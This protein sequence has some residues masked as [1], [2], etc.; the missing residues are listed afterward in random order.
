MYVY[1]QKLYIAAQSVFDLCSLNLVWALAARL[2][3][4]LNPSMQLHLTL[5][6]SAGWVPPMGLVLLLWVIV[7]V[8]LKLYRIPH[9]VGVFTLLEGAAKNTVVLCVLTV[10]ATFFSMQFGGGASRF[11]VLCMLPVALLVLTAT[12]VLTLGMVALVQHRAQ[13][14]RIALIGD[15]KDAKRLV[16]RMRSHV[17]SD[18][19][20]VI[21]PEGS[22]AEKSVAA[23]PVL[24]TTGQIAELVNRERIERVIMLKGTLP[25]SEFDRCHKVFWRMGLPVTC[26]LDLAFEPGP[27][28]FGWGSGRRVD[29]WKQYGLSIVEVRPVRLTG[30]QDFVKNAFD[31]L[32]AAASLALLSPLLLAIAVSI[33][34]TSEGPVFDQ[35]ARRVGKGGRHF[36]CIKFR[37]AC[38]DSRPALPRPTSERSPLSQRP[39]DQR[40][41][42]VGS[43]LL[44]YSLDELPQLINILRREMSFVGPRPLPADDLG[45][46]GMSQEFFTWSDLRARVHP[47]LT[48]LWQVNGR[49]T[50]SLDDMIRLDLE[51]VQNRSLWLDLSIILQ[52]PMVVLRG[53][54]AH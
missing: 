52:T 41:T 30:V 49:N 32:F 36:T 42:P 7:S 5:Q 40:I 53:V 15:L 14:P 23:L 12:R 35:V 47:G 16:G 3:I 33:K 25:D 39:G 18:I 24:G 1:R 51:Y 48:G 9:E 29:F 6:Q 22:T 10:L 8:R 34:L 21:V 13:P 54:G 27:A 50:L 43:F 2:R 11:F 19:R 26:T 20:G 4:L 37:T 31:F 45:P 17:G 28:S 44:R 38:I 46:D